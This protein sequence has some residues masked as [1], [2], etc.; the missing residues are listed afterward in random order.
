MG[1]AEQLGIA[2]GITS[3]V[4][5][6]GKS[7]LLA[8]LAHELPGTVVLT[9]T[10]HILPFEGIVTLVEPSEEEVARTLSGTRAACVGSPAGGGKLAAPTTVSLSRLAEIAPYVLVEADGSRRLPL[11]AHAPWEPVVPKGTGRTV[12]VVG[13]SGFGRPVSEAAH[14][15]DRFCT[16]AGCD[17]QDLATPELVARVIR[18]EGLGDVIVVNQ[19]DG[20][21]LV[22][23]AGVL[24]RR[25]EVPVL[26]G[27]LRAG[28]L[29]GPLA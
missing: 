19:A 26:A 4:G 13:A 28:A 11:K 22:E 15:P 5:S 27:S 17:P 6:G 10:T 12:L 8:A 14:R 1:L 21:R 7:T 24:A 25:I 18:A 20:P 29:A 16:L 9:T 2:Q 3:V 23:L